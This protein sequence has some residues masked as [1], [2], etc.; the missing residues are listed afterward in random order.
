GIGLLYKDSLRLLVQTSTSRKIRL[1][2]VYRPQ[3]S[4]DHSRVP[5]NTFL[6]EFSDVMESTILSK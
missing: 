1:V 2:I 5:I 6:M 4:D 3:N